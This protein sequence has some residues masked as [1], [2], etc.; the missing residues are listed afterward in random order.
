MKKITAFEYEGCPYCEQGKKA[1][2]ELI[3]E[4]PEYGKI[5][6]EWIEE[7]EHPEIIANYNYQA[8]PSM[9]IGKEK[10]YE[11]HLYETFEE[12]KENIRKVF[13]KAVK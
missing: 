9:F 5:E 8:T 4:N 13:E 6:I 10:L 11:A 12:C 3:K 1:I 2:D 7:H